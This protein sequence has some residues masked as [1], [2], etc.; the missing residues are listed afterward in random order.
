MRGEKEDGGKSS[1]FPRP[2]NQGKAKRGIAARNAVWVLESREWCQWSGRRLS[3]SNLR[4]NGKV[5][6]FC[7]RLFLAQLLEKRLRVVQ[8]VSSKKSPVYL[9]DEEVKTKL[10][11]AQLLFLCHLVIDFFIPFELGPMLRCARLSHSSH[12]NSKKTFEPWTIK[13]IASISEQC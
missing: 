4:F 10:E 5:S 11:M 3:A 7:S 9:V 6:C 2:L 13:R 12:D 8:Q 1:T